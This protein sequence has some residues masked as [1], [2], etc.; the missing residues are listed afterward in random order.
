MPVFTVTNSLDDLK[1]VGFSSKKD[2]RDNWVFI[3]VADPTRYVTV[4][5]IFVLD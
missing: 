5:S 2:G 1:E 4:R 3:H